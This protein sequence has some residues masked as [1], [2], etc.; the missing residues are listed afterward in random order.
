MS[1]V[2]KIFINKARKILDGGYFEEE[3]KSNVRPKWD[4]KD[5]SLN[6]YTKYL[7]QEFVEYEQ[8]QVPI[9]NLRKIA[10]KTAIKEILWIYKDKCNDVNKL[11]D[12][13]GVMYWDSWMNEE[14]S[15]GTAY[16]YQTSKTFKSPET[17]EYINQVD[18]LISQLRT[19]PLN[20]RLIISLYDVDDLSDMTLI[21]CAFLTMWSVRGNY[22]DMTLVQRSGDFLAAA[23]PGGINAF[24]Y[25]VLLR[26]VAQVTGYEAG[27]FV[28]FVQNLHIYDRHIEMVEEIIK[29]DSDKEGPSLWINPE[30]KELEDF[31][32]DDFKLIDYKPSDKKYKI[33]IAI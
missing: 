16:G 23:G 21:P 26:M 9:T 2:D 5:C 15:L 31:T 24:Q 17:G 6:A 20:R 13:Y 22:L 7:T 33:P 30:V 10:W 3:A 14:G 27:N 4:D 28:H 32:I 1:K 19:N 18:R 29:E 8:G 11:K 25:Y 12:K